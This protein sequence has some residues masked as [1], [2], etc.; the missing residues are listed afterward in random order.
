MKEAATG[1]ALVAAFYFACL[2]ARAEAEAANGIR[3][4]Y[5]LLFCA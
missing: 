2:D 3:V 4:F 1:A 5:P